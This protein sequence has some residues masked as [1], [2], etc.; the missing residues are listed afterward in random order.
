MQGLKSRGKRFDFAPDAGVANFES[1][2]QDPEISDVVIIGHGGLSYANAQPA[3]DTSEPELVDWWQLSDM[4]DHLKQ[5]FFIQRTCG[6]TK[7]HLNV[8]LGL[9]VVSDARN[10]RAAVGRP[11]TAGDVESDGYAPDHLFIPVADQE[12]LTRADVK[13]LFPKTPSLID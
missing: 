13:R 6:E 10:I 1:V 5:G 11:I 4:S 7:R 2:V 12:R 9:F 3:T 8:P